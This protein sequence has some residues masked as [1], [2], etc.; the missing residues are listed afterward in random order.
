MTKDKLT[1]SALVLIFLLFSLNC[2]AQE[3]VRLVDSSMHLRKLPNYT[4][5]ITAL[6][7]MPFKPDTVRCIMMISDTS[8]SYHTY[9]QTDSIQTSKDYLTGHDVKIDE[10]FANQINYWVIGYCFNTDRSKIFWQYLDSDKKPLSKN[11]IV[12]QS[13]NLEK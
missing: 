2:R 3:V 12:W 11:I 6:W 10:G 1:G 8:H 9:F 5:T 13:Q 7:E 4:G